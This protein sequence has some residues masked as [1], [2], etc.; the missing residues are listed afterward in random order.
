[1][2]TENS[3]LSAALKSA[4]ANWGWYVALGIGLILAGFAASI[5]FFAST[6]A[7]IIYIAAMMLA[8]S[9]LQIA[10]A[11]SA[12]SWKRRAFD[13]VSALFYG[14][15]SAVLIMDPVLSAIDISLVIGALLVA[16]GVFRVATGLHARSNKGWVWIFASG[17][18][19]AAV[20]VVILITW[21]Q[22][23]L[24]LLGAMLTVDLLFQGCGFLAFGLALRRRAG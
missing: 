22:V 10:H 17:V 3:S 9:A 2:V 16:A 4:Q 23:G 15:A 19:T 5:N 14:V 8:G 12:R 18:M 24:G 1:M 13:L 11:L 7:S 21:P 6:L 20:G